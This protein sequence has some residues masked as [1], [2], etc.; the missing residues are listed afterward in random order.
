MKLTPPQNYKNKIKLNLC[1]ILYINLILN[2]L[3]FMVTVKEE[4]KVEKSLD[5]KLENQP[6]GASNEWEKLDLKG[7]KNS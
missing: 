7:E 5:R 6:V 3:F 2:E 1:T 4:S